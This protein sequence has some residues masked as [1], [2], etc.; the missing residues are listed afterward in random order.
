MELNDLQ[1]TWRTLNKDLPT[2]PK[3]ALDT[4][5]LKQI[6][7]TR[8]KGVL[9][10]LRVN[11]I[12]ELWINMACAVGIF[13]VLVLE[14]NFVMRLVFSGFMVYEVLLGYY[15]YRKLHLL[16]QFASPDESLKTYLTQLTKQ[17][18]WFLSIYKYGNAL[19]MPPAFLAGLFMG[20]YYNSTGFW[21]RWLSQD[22]GYNALI[23]A[24]LTLLASV[25][26]YVVITWWTNRLYGVHLARLEQYIQELQD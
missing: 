10:D 15:F 6:L 23:I 1:K 22:I 19:L 13:V 25:F 11:S 18:H 8:S 24:G 12:R 2:E 4:A 17:L 9:E 26:G 20:G 21:A 16:H 7:Q 3:L 14:N 5:G